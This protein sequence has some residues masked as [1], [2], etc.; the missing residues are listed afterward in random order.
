M[1]AELR[2][3]TYEFGKTVSMNKLKKLYIEPSSLCNLNCTMC[4]RHGWIDEKQ[5]LMTT[6]TR[7]RVIRSIPYCKDLETVM[8]AGMGEPLT[9]PEIFDMVADVSALDISTHLLTNGT[10]LDRNRTDELLKC[11]LD[12]L[13]VSVDGFSKGSYEKIQLGSQYDL[14]LE[15]LLYFTAHKGNCKLGITFVI[16]KENADELCKI[17]L[18]ADMLGADEINLSHAI[19][20][21]PT[22]EENTLYSSDVS[23]GKMIRFTKQN[24]E[25]KLNLC[26]FV[27]E[28]V[29]FVKSNGDVCPCMQ[30][31]HSSYTYLFEERRKVISCSFGNVSENLLGDIWNEEPYRNFRKKVINFEFPDCTLCDGCDDRLENQTDCM[32]NSFPTCGAC[33]W[34]QG[35]VRCP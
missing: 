8:F 28:G 26:P 3:C 7:E 22:K 25:R 19:P 9:H 5:E 32:F 34:A 18:F 16:M 29:M 35:V 4:F 30:L 21:V 17:N 23:V 27:D 6:E 12:M 20:S 24:A 13:W 15:N 14:I 2:Q 33:L 11:G 31:L 1:Q 10:L